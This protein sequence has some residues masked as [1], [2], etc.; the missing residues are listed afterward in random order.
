MRDFNMFTEAG[1]AYVARI[2][3]RAHQLTDAGYDIETV[4]N[5]ALN[6]L[7]ALATKPGFEEADDTAVREAVYDS[8]I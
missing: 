7:S 4:W 8:V 1:N 6:E 2:V 5:N 3:S